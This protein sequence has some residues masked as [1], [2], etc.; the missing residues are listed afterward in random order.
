[1]EYFSED[2]VA[3]KHIKLYEQVVKATAKAKTKA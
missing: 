3:K 1:M 2:T